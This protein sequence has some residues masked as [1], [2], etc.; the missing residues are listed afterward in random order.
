M[1]HFHKLLTR[2]NAIISE[3]PAEKLQAWS[4]AHHSVP[5]S[6]QSPE[7]GKSSSW[8][9]KETPFLKYGEPRPKSSEVRLF[10]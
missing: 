3:G 8:N 5:S 7:A 6:Q 9:S 10:A 2:G 4:D 1:L